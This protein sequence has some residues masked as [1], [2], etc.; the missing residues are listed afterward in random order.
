MDSQYETEQRQQREAR[1]R[2]E[3][4]RERER[5]D[6]CEHQRACRLMASP[7]CLKRGG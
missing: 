7:V 3:R 6:N 2:Q 4:Q 1:E 5:C